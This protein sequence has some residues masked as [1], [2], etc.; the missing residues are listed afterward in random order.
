MM[1]QLGGGFGVPPPP[2]N[3]FTGD[4][5]QGPAPDY[6]DAEDISDIVS[7]ISEGDTKD[8]QIKAAPKRRGRKKKT[9][10]T[11]INI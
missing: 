3:T 11:E 7:V 5:D 9:D 4:V 1:G 10:K 6:N 8:L 2:V